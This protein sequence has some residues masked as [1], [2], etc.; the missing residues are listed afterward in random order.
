MYPTRQLFSLCHH[1][2][3][4]PQFSIAQIAACVRLS[5]RIFRRI[6]FMWALTVASVT[7]HVRAITLLACPFT[8]PSRIW[9]SRS[10]QPG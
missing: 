2:L 4:R 9:T 1:P 10:D 8:R 3:H 6:D 7:S 5:T